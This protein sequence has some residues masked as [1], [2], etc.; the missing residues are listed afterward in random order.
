MVT[1]LFKVYVLVLISNGVV[2]IKIMECVRGRIIKLGCARK[3]HKVY[4][5]I[6]S[7]H[8]RESRTVLDSPFPIQ[9]TGFQYLSLELGF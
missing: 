5:M 7:P 9:E 6:S 8:V 3:C 1:M 4:L 2:T